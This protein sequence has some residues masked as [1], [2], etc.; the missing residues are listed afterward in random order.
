MIWSD[1]GQDI[2]LEDTADMRYEGNVWCSSSLIIFY[3][4]AV[5]PQRCGGYE[6]CRLHQ[7]FLAPPPI[8]M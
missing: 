2:F 4:I 3:G 6:V 7:V 5:M 8:V 1:T